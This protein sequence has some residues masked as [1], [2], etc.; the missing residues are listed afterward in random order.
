MTADLYPK[1]NL[2]AASVYCA[3]TAASKASILLFYLRIFPGRVFM[4]AVWTA[5]FFVV[6][7]NVASIFADI[8]SCNPVAMSWD[9]TI[10]TGTCINR[11]LLYFANAGLGIFADFVTLLLPL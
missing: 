8:F 2:L 1:F 5:A 6:S 4:F 3:A 11:P 10:L 9:V 7:Y